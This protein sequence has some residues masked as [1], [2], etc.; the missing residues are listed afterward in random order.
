MFRL[1]SSFV[2]CSLTAGVAMASPTDRLAGPAL[3]APT[4]PRLELYPAIDDLLLGATSKHVYVNTAPSESHYMLTIAA[5]TLGGALVGFLIGGA[6]YLLQDPD[7]RQPVN[8]A[9]WTGGGALV[10]VG[11]GVVQVIVRANR[12]D[13]AVSRRFIVPAGT[14][15]V[16]GWTHSF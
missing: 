9:W 8:L 13:E 12:D 14:R 16:L 10:G 6:I 15:Q 2:L 11:A 4:S 7:D 3:A 1:A 5:N